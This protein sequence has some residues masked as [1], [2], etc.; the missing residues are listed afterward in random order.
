MNKLTSY[1]F[2]LTDLI[3]FSYDMSPFGMAKNDP[4]AANVFELFH[5]D[6]TGEGTTFP[7]PRVLT[8]YFNTVCQ[9]RFDL[10][11]VHKWRRHNHIY[12]ISLKK[13]LHR[14]SNDKKEE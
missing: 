12:H 9:G 11:D 14:D 1:K 13:Q 6:F 10:V 4:F 5:A 3:L 8:R 7:N 2:L